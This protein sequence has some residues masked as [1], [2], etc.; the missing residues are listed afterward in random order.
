MKFVDSHAHINT[1][2]FQDDREEVIAKAFQED[3]LAILCPAELAESENLRIAL[4]LNTRYQNIV[5]AAGIHPHIYFW[6]QVLQNRYS[7]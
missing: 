7:V 6:V 5:A 3:I 2:E 4:D 1:K